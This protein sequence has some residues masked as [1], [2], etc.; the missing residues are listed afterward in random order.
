MTERAIVAGILRFVTTHAAAHR[1]IGFLE[2]LF[3]VLDRTMALLA[4]VS[5]IEMSF[6]TEHHIGWNLIDARPTNF[7]LRLRELGQFLDC[8]TIGLNRR[9]A[10]HAGGSLRNAHSLTRFLIRVTHVAF[11]LQLCDMLLMAVR[12]RLLGWRFWWRLGE[13]GNDQRHRQAEA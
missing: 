12:N 9:M 7:A 4:S 13:S 6:V 10:L 2:Q 5:G 8:R 1:D 3:S 11:E